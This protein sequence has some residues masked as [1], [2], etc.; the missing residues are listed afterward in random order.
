MER[1]PGTGPVALDGNEKLAV[2]LGPLAFFMGGYFL[3]GKVGPLLDGLFGTEL[4]A[5]PSG[6]LYCAL[7]LFLPAFVVAFAYSIVRTKRVAPM[8]AITGAIV[9]LTGTLTFV[10]QNKAFTYMKPTAIYGITALV[11]GGGLFFRQIFLRKLF[12]GAFDMPDDKWRILTWRFVAYNAAAAVAN[13]IAWRTLTADCVPD[14]ECAG[15]A[16]WVNLKLFGFTLAYFAF[17]AANAPFLMK[18]AAQAEGS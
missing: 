17:I 18:H 12:G 13:E 15:E 2:E 11:L 10:F 9:L 6:E 4:F 8:L 5:E 1:A 14:V 16:V 3:N 7:A